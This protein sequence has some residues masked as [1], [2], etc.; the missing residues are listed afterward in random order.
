MEVIKVTETMK[1]NYN[2]YQKTINN[3]MNKI[4]A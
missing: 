2:Q 4:Q 1:D 3:M